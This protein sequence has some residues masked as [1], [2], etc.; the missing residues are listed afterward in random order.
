MSYTKGIFSCKNL[1]LFKIAAVYQRTVGQQEDLLALKYRKYSW[2]LRHIEAAGSPTFFLLHIS[3]WTT[4]IHTS[5]L[6]GY[7]MLSFSPSS[8]TVVYCVWPRLRKIHSTP[9]IHLIIQLCSRKLIGSVLW[10]LI[11]NFQRKGSLWPSVDQDVCSISSAITWR[12]GSHPRGYP[13]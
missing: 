2:P 4:R 6:C 10:V 9:L 5:A 12:V 11:L 3:P 1:K 13:L 7:C 8:D